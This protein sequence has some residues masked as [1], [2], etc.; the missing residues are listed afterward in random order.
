MPVKFTDSE[1]DYVTIF[2]DGARATRTS[3][4]LLSKE[5]MF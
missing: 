1:I 4:Q 2:R 5:P 3:T